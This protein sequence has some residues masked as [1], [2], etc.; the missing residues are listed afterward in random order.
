MKQTE[1]SPTLE[2]LGTANYDNWYFFTKKS[3][4]L[5]NTKNLSP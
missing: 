5:L 2:G 4:G 1:K 3:R